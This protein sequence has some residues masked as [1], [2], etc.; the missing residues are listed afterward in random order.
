M[1]GTEICLRVMHE[2]EL[3]IKNK[4]DLDVNQNTTTCYFEG[5]LVNEVLSI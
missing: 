3:Q 5:V 2:N 4:N 1:V